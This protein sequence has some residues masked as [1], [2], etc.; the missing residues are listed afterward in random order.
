MGKNYLGLPSGSSGKESACQWSR[1]KR[2]DSIPGWGQAW[3]AITHGITKSRTWL[4]TPHLQELFYLVSFKDFCT[5]RY[6][7][8][9]VDWVSMWAQTFHPQAWG[10]YIL[11]FFKHLLWVATFTFSPCVLSTTHPSCTFDP[12]ISQRLQLPRSPRNSTLLY[13]LRSYTIFADLSAELTQRLFPP[14]W[15]PSLSGFHDYTLFQCSF[16][17]MVTTF[18]SPLLALAYLVTCH[19]ILSSALDSFLP[20]PVQWL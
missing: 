5:K 11:S 14:S 2:I 19:A 4:S 20:Y 18:Q 17:W 9:V 8:V 6:F 1:H 10:K 13:Y 12:I 16:L 7:K 15:N 3:R